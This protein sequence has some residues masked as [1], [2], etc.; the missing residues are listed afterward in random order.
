M[1]EHTLGRKIIDPTVHEVKI[2]DEFHAK[3]AEVV[4]INA[5]SGHA[6]MA[7][8]DAF[9][10]GTERLRHLILVHGELEQM[11]PL[12]ARIEHVRPGVTVHTPE[13]DEEIVL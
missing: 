3:R 7:D 5:Y 2:F 11:Q 10:L 1:A 8:L 4:S 9:I 13:R 12:Q 6:D